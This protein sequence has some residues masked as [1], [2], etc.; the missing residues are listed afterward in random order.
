MMTSALKGDVVERMEGCLRRGHFSCDLKNEVEVTM[1]RT[2]GWAFLAE[3][4]ACA[5]VLNRMDLP[6]L[7][8]REG[9]TLAGRGVM[10][11]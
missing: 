6:C 9:E 1:G 3:G 4:I 2:T 5:K 8:N 11:Q 10:E 7:R